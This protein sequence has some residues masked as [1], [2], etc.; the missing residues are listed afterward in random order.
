MTYFMKRKQPKLG[1]LI[2]AL[3]NRKDLFYKNQCPRTFYLFSILAEQNLKES[4]CSF[5]SHKQNGGQTRCVSGGKLEKCGRKWKYKSATNINA[6][7]RCKHQRIYLLLTIY[8]LATKAEA[9]YARST[10][11]FHG[12]SAFTRILL[13][14]F[15]Y[16]FY[17]FQ[18]FHKNTIYS[19]AKHVHMFFYLS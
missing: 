4:W 3:I 1:H 14:V 11:W 16:Y 8:I 9:T 5:S 12:P 17:L 7:K 10:V 2:L 6:Q 18:F 15:I 13:Y 19:Q